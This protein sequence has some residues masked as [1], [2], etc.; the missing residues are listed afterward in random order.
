M[1]SLQVTD[2][3]CGHCASKIT[4][5]V[6]AADP[7]ALVAVDPDALVA[8]DL[9]THRVSIQ[10][11]T[12]DAGDLADAIKGAGYTPLAIDEPAGPTVAAVPELRKGCRCG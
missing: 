6:R 7:D 4:Q 1:L 9:A 2:M 12:A 10:P 5:A 8:V 3:T 11:I